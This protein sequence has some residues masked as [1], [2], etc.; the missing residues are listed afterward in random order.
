MFVCTCV[1]VPTDRSRGVRSP[2]VGAVSSSV[3]LNVGARNEP[4][5]LC[6]RSSTIN[7]EPSSLQSSLGLKMG[8]CVVQAGLEHSIL[9]PLPSECLVY[10]HTAPHGTELQV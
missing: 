2:T 3:M 10:R 8:F 5:F 9:L 1:Q 6:Q 7:C 4:S